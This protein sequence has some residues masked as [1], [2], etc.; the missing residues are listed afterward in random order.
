VPVSD[1]QKEKY[2]SSHYSLF[3]FDLFD[4]IIQPRWKRI[5]KTRELDTTSQ[6]VKFNNDLNC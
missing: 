2:T 6:L 1:I 3:L 5:T 4:F